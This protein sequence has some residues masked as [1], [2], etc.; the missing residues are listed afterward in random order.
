VAA[1]ES[2]RLRRYDGLMVQSL[3]EALAA[4]GL[5]LRARMAESPASRNAFVSAAA[6]HL[7]ASEMRQRQATQ[8]YS[9]VLPITVG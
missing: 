7:S 2:E 3:D 9:Q 1:D 4:A 8:A 6:S 5:L